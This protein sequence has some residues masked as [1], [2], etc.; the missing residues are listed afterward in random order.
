MSLFK[1]R[2]AL[3][4]VF[5]HSLGLN[6]HVR[7]DVTF[8]K[9][10][11][12]EGTVDGAVTGSQGSSLAVGKNG[13]INGGVVADTVLV[14]G[15]VNGPIQAKRIILAASCTVQGDLQAQ[16][17]DI[18]DG[19]TF[20]GNVVIRQPAQQPQGTDATSA[21]VAKGRLKVELAGNHS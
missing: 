14:E 12:V 15:A 7:G 8:E 18:Q 3:K 19:A 11:L 16:C 20:E 6:T 10:M 9:G 21:S 1:P 5:V 17:V 13:C 4:L 2:N